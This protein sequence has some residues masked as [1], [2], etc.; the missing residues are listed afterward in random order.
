VSRTGIG[1]LENVLD[2]IRGVADVKWW[3]GA[4]ILDW[5]RQASA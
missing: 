2:Y 3:T 5:Y 1:W 4:Q